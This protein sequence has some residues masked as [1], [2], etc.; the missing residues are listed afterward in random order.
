MLLMM[1]YIL[2]LSEF[3]TTVIMYFRHC[4][5]TDRSSLLKLVLNIVCEDQRILRAN[6]F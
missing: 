5:D 2:I 1:R 6:A 3:K 4:S